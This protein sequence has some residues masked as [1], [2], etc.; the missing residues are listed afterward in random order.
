S[1]EG[2]PNILTEATINFKIDVNTINTDNEDRDNH[3]RSDDFFEVEKYPEITFK[4][5][6]IVETG[7]DKYD[8][9][10][11]LTDKG[12]TKEATFKL[13]KTGEGT[14]PWGVKVVAFEGETKISREQYGLTWNQVLETGGVLVGDDIKINV[15]VQ[16]NP[17]E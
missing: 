2:D 15:E 12:N 6:K 14:N 16:L 9:I 10:G 4:S 11:D 7:N 5:T 8:V 1:I 3:L 17:A 13:E